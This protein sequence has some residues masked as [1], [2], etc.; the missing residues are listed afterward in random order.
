[1]MTLIEHILSTEDPYLRLVGAK[2]CDLLDQYFTD[3]DC[4]KEDCKEQL[5]LFAE[6]A[7]LPIT[8]ERMIALYA[9]PTG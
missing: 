7:N 5:D 1:M 4:D 3:G 8:A 2:L 9:E 6:S